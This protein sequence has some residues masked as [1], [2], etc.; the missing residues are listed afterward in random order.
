MCIQTGNETDSYSYQSFNQ[1]ST[2]SSFPQTSSNM[3]TSTNMNFNSDQTFFQNQNLSSSYSD[4][5]NQQQT[6]GVSQIIQRQSPQ[7]PISLPSLA[8]SL[9]NY[10]TAPSQNNNQPVV[11][12]TTP[13]IQ[14]EQQPI[15][16]QMI[17]KMHSPSNKDKEKEAD[18]ARKKGM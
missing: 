18:K 3:Q 1:T 4:N 6:T 10:S 8:G 15:Q 13:Q 7:G 9:K 14:Q 12:P 16:T 11:Q 5:Y 17:P 2:S